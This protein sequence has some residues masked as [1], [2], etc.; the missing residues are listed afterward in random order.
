MLLLTAVIGDRALDSNQF[1]PLFSELAW[2]WFSPSE[3]LI[4]GLVSGNWDTCLYRGRRGG[5]VGFF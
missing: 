2:D 1:S 3:G 4:Q 5:V